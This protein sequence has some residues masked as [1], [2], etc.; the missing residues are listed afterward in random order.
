MLDKK[1]TRM[2]TKIIVAIIGA[3]ALIFATLY[4][5]RFYHTIHINIDGQSLI[6]AADDVSQAFIDLE[7]LESKYKQLETEYAIA[8]GDYEE[9]LNDEYDRGYNDG[10][11]DSADI[12]EPMLIAEYN[13]GLAKGKMTSTGDIEMQLRAEYERGYVD[14]IKAQ[15]NDDPSN[16]PVIAYFEDSFINKPLNVKWDVEGTW[17]F[18]G[19]NGLRSERLR[20]GD[21]YL[22]LTDI[23]EN[24]Q[25]YVVEFEAMGRGENRGIFM[26]SPGYGD[27]SF[28]DAISLYTTGIWHQNG[29]RYHRDSSV[30]SELAV[31]D[32][33]IDKFYKIRI[34]IDN[35]N[36]KMDIYIDGQVIC[37][38]GYK[39]V[40]RPAFAFLQYTTSRDNNVYF[41]RNFT[42]TTYMDG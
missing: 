31:L 41:I 25:R 30:D 1:K 23:V 9:K 35:I 22:C 29:S 32:L 19:T 6:V 7:I 2:N 33:Q 16:S 15:N 36:R 5:S 24:A 13:K 17:T 42:L 10:M 40:V 20:S 28:V 21:G 3:V 26:F 39:N 37:S 34:E 38:Y 12:Y 4:G 11:H 27:V 14:S 18:D 8:I